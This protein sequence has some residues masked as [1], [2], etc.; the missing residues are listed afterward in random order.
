MPEVASSLPLMKAEQAEFAA[1]FGTDVVFVEE[2]PGSGPRWLIR[3]DP[4]RE[5]NTLEFDSAS[6]TL[7][8]HAKDAG[9]VKTTLNLLNSLVGL[10]VDRIT[11]APAASTAE[12]VDHADRGLPLRGPELSYA[13]LARLIEQMIKRL[14]RFPRIAARVEE[15]AVNYLAIATIAMIL[16]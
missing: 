3:I 7:T 2:D 6:L 14:K 1:V 10:G 8:S 12:A 16:E 13:S 4:E 9:G 5:Y 11:D 15:Q